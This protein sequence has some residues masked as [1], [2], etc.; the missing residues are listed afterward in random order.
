MDAK[1]QGGAS[2]TAGPSAA[3]K[4]AGTC[5]TNGVTDR[6]MGGMSV[7]KKKEVLKSF[8]CS[9]CRSVGLERGTFRAR[10]ALDRQ[11]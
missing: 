4:P 5:M 2:E 8:L 9:V 1:A 6:A 7:S 3:A 11:S 10:A